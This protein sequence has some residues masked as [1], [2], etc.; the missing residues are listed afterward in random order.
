MPKGILRKHVGQQW[1]P[2][3]YYG[4]PLTIMY[5]GMGNLN[6]EIAL[7]GTLLHSAF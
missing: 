2:N 5:Q 4:T 3:Q 7:S 6:T 1:H